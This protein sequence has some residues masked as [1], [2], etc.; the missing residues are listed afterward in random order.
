MCND[1]QTK[2]ENILE[3]NKANLCDV[4]CGNRLRYDAENTSNKMGTHHVDVIKMKTS[5]LLLATIFF[6]KSRK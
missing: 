6:K 5:V 3:E 1:N 4:E 2:S